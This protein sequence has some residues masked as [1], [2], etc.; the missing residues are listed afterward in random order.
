[1]ENAASV[2]TNCM[3]NPLQQ[4]DDDF[5]SISK[6]SQDDSISKLTDSLGERLFS[7]VSTRISSGIIS[8]L[9]K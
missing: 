8:Q 5:N 2:T 4:M 1:M 9:A 6:K 3:P 7:S